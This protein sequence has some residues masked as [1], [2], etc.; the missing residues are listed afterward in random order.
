MNLL[1]TLLEILK[2]D[3]RFLADGK[4]LKNKIIESALKLDTALIELLLSNNEIKKVFFVVLQTSVHVFNKDKFIK[5]VSNKEFL[6]NSYTSFKNK[7]GLFSDDIY[8]KANND[9]VLAWPYKD[10]VLEGGQNRDD[11]KCNEIF[12]NE[13]L[14][15]NEIDRL[16]DPKVF[17]NF[18]KITH[19]EETVPTEISS[20]DNLAIKGNNLL[21]L[22]SLYKRY[23]EAIKCIYIDPPYNTGNDSFQYNDSFNHASWLTFMKNRLEIAYKLLSK[24]GLIFISIDD[25]E[26]A[27]LKILMDEIFGRENFVNNII[28]RRYDKNLNTQF[29][30]KGLK[31]LNTGVEYVL[32]YSKTPTT[33]NPVFREAD[34][35]RKESGYWKGFWNDA[36]RP[37]MRYDIHGYVPV[38][39]QWKWQESRAIKAI[40]N[41]EE[42]EEKYK[43]KM[44]L[45]EYWSTTGKT[46]EFICRKLSGKGK[47]KGVEHWISPSDEILRTS[48]WTDVLASK[49][50]DLDFDSPKNPELIKELIKM[51]SGD[52]DIILDFFGGSGTTAEAVLDLNNE[53]EEQRQ[54]I[55]CE[56]MDYFDK[57]TLQRIKNTINSNKSGNVVTCS[58]VEY[59]QKFINAIKNEKNTNEILKIF[60]EVKT[61]G[62]L[63]F[64]FN[65]EKW[66]NN[67]NSFKELALIDQ[68]Q[69]LIDLLDKNQIYIPYDEIEDEEFN[70]SDSIKRLNKNFY[71]GNQ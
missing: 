11:A 19:N 23:P 45:E 4:L 29:I 27:Y 58:L 64:N 17:A 71:Q 9:V 38:E 26:H 60:N 43:D 51:G 35:K 68:K 1:N 33:I 57:T 18:R 31:S 24:D 67:L 3:E 44:S 20:T 6:P 53:S 49:S 47:N 13:T 2:T 28:V 16:Y 37:T 59:N 62:F 63:N 46:K 36:D 5:F 10:C 25:Y 32:V 70:I 48:N 56:Q 15:S 61:K 40:K 12:W 66:V 42:Y 22:H 54:F 65:E 52:G 21:A 69:T 34:G 39:G 14:A 7:I 30:N 50:V 41:Y 8:L 55:I